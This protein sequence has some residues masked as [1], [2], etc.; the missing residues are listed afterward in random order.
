MQ[1][2]NKSKHKGVSYDEKGMRWSGEH[3]GKKAKEE[4]KNF[5]VSKFGE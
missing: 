3:L 2:N 5:S 4:G 1:K